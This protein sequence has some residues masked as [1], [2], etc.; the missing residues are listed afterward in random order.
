MSQP[1]PSTSVAALVDLASSVASKEAEPEALH[2]VL[3][4]RLE[5]VAASREDFERKAEA[6]GEGFTVP[7]AELIDRVQDCYD[8]YEQSLQTMLAYFESGNAKDL[9]SGG[10]AL[11]EV[12]A[13]MT[14]VVA[15]YVKTLVGHGPSPYPLLNGATNILRSVATQGVP[16]AALKD[17]VD[18]MVAEHLKAIAEIDAAE[19]GKRAGYQDKKTA[20]AAVNLALRGLKPVASEDAI[21]AEVAA[22]KTAL[23]QM[24]AADTSIFAESI[25]GPTAM[26]AANTLIHTARG[27][28]DGT[29][30]LEA[31]EE[32]L[33]FYKEYLE[34]VE[35]QF[36]SAV[37]GETDSVVILEEL[38]KTREIIDQHDEVVAELAAAL[39]EEFTAE[40]VEP[41]IEDLIDV[42][43]RLKDSSDVYM[44]VAKREGK[45]VCVSCGHPNAPTN[46]TCEECGFRLPQLVDPNKFAKSTVELEERSGLGGD[47]P[48]GGVVTENTYKLW[49]ACEHFFAQKISE[50]EFRKLLD[51][52]REQVAQ[53][54]RTN[55][56]IKEFRPSEEMLAN[57]SPEEVELLEDNRKL[58]EDTKHLYEEAIDD[59][60]EGLDFMENFI[61]TRHR[62]TIEAGMKKVWAASQKLY[63]LHKIGELAKRALD[64][65][66]EYEVNNPESDDAPD[67]DTGEDEDAVLDI[68]QRDYVE[69]EGGLA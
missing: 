39:E 24:T 55:K 50:A 31:M 45:L 23:E 48:V 47:E 12:V 26:P 51:W 69:G 4:Q 53:S 44:D 13:P 33:E 60:I 6:M 34:A 52:S 56:R 36:N 2:A 3:T 40:V 14:E 19:A 28:L 17:F 25:S 29:Y 15:E 57:A 1:T 27:V 21:E 67:D 42:I 32:A 22:L 46:R 43:E 61:E 9:H 54:E 11:I 10:Q 18:Q 8:Q 16:E 68:E 35:Q 66:E 58:F 49:E 5:M 63:S 20:L 62:P 59:W 38:P 37:E 41:I 7:N 64:E 30:D 65:R